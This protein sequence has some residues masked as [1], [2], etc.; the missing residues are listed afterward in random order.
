MPWEVT[1]QRSDLQALGDLATIR[2]G[3][4]TAIP[5][6]QYYTEPSGIQKLEAAAKMGVEFPDVL[7]KHFENLPA[8]LHAVY[9]SEDLTISIF[10]FESQPLNRLHAEIR[11]NQNPAPILRTLCVQNSW[12]ALDDQTGSAIDLNDTIPTQWLEFMGYRDSILQEDNGPPSA[13]KA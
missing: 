2:R 12:S 7:K 10:G 4:E 11:G 3:I 13:D 5:D 6:I 9:S 8:K 1:F